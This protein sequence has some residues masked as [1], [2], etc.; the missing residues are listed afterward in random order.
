LILLLKFAQNKDCEFFLGSEFLDKGLRL[1]LEV[2]RFL[3]I[4]V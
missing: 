3:A 2:W 4:K 1:S